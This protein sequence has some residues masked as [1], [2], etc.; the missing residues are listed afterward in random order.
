MHRSQHFDRNIYGSWKRCFKINLRENQARFKEN[1]GNR[2]SSRKKI[3]LSYRKWHRKERK[4]VPRTFGPV[5]Q[6]SKKLGFKPFFV[7]P[8]KQTRLT[9]KP[10]K[11]ETKTVK[12][13]GNDYQMLRKE[14]SN[15]VTYYRAKPWALNLPYTNGK[16]H[17]LRIFWRE[18]FQT[19]SVNHGYKKLEFQN[20]NQN[21]Y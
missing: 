18:S 17:V 9:H 21:Q 13:K 1:I 11:V 16:W 10:I 20:S 7:V 4:G 19:R 8:V 6:F 2:N 15:F 12:Y 14:Y 5:V 3:I